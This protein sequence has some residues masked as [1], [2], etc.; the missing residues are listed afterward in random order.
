[1]EIPLSTTTLNSIA[2][3]VVGHYSEAAKHLI[4]AYSTGTERAFA[5]V[6]SEQRLAGFV[7][8]AVTQVSGRASSAVDHV[9]TRAVEG[10]EAFGA[11]TAWASDLMVVNALRSINLPAA[12]LSLEIANK[13]NQ[14]SRRLSE[15][16]ASVEAQP[17]AARK[18]PRAR[19]SAR[20]A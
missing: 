16:V 8:D 19:R 15:R 11:K 4:N 5:F 12:K 10:M 7:V 13:L 17:A 2:I 14:A 20:K 6:G 9:S 18:A 3:D 1:M